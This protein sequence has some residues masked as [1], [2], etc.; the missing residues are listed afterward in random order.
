MQPA[1]AHDPAAP[2]HIRPAERADVDRLVALERLAFST[3]RMARRSVRRFVDNPH[4]SMMVAE[5]G[6]IIE[7]YALVLFREGSDVARLYSIA[8][9]PH[10]TGRGL[11]KA[12]LE[13]AEDAA[14]AR[15]RGVLRL[16]VH[17]KNAAA[18]RRYEK[19]GY[20]RF[21]HHAHYYE[22]RGHALRFQKRLTPRL[23]GHDKAPPYFHQTTEFTCGPAC[24]MM[25]LAW[26]EPSWRPT[27]AS[28]FELW[29]EATTIFMSSGPGG[30]EPYGL[31]LAVRRRGL[32]PEIHV[33]RPGPYFLDTVRSNDQRGVMRLVQDEFRQEAAALD[34]PTRLAPLGESVLMT[35]FDQ[36][37]VAIV[38]VAGYHMVRRSV[39]HWVFA[40]GHDGGRILLHDPA[41]IRDADGRATAAETYAIPWT[42]FQ[43]VARFGRDNLTA[44][45][46]I[47]KGPPP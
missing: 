17:E 41:A 5:R 1:V 47:R 22:D 20:R 46:L 3:D 7:G 38:L 9:A 19:S 39:P 33:A 35:A 31:A 37:A 12:L 43:R 45:I 14:M 42:R 40:F 16:E 23:A 6:G 15:D 26:A 24:V 21:G 13:A 30:C 4:A 36:G 27:A 8:V 29:R 10:T 25:A 32:R 44:A 11:G 34:I 2:V 18:I 28:E